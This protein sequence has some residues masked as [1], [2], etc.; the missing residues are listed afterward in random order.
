MV[1]LNLEQLHNWLFNLK[2]NCVVTVGPA[3]LEF[4]DEYN[5]YIE[6][7]IL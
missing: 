7:D 3:W 2:R 6:Y 5:T 1:Y 4:L